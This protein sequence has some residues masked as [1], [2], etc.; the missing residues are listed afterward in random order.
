VIS[1][2]RSEQLPPHSLTRKLIACA[3]HSELRLVQPALALPPKP[4][5]REPPR[6]RRDL[7]RS[8]R[9]VNKR[10]APT[11]DGDFSL[12]LKKARIIAQALEA[13]FETSGRSYPWRQSRDPYRLAVA[14]IL[15]QRTRADVVSPL[16]S[17]VILAYPSSRDLASA[18]LRSLRKVLRPLGLF[19]KRAKSLRSLGRA[20]GKAGTAVFRNPASAMTLPGIGEYGSRA[21]SCFAF[22]Q[23][24]GIVDANVRRV[25]TRLL[26]LPS[27]DARDSRYQQLADKMLRASE[28]PRSTNFGLLD[29]GAMVC[30]P[31]PRCTICPLS[32]SC[33]YARAFKI[34]ESRK[35]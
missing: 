8:L 3:N 11:V 10:L 34:E 7:H 15:L 9:S 21:I 30:G 16:Y 22:R 23:K 24:I 25:L 4:E 1:T 17:K 14:E 13:F 28:D 33:K 32:H 12:T 6:I 5:L 18:D 29:L 35:R 2:K 19:N 27:M 20:I 31:R 26:D